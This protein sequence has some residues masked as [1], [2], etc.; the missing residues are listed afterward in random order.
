[1]SKKLVFLMLGYLGSLLLLAEISLASELSLFRGGYK[2]TKRD[3]GISSTQ[4]GLGTRYALTPVGDMAYFGQ[5]YV[6]QTS[7]G[8]SGTKPENGS[9]ME[10]GGG[11]LFYT[12]RLAP[13]LA[14]YFSFYG[15][16]K[17][18]KNTSDASPA[19]EKIT[20]L[21]YGASFGM[22]IRFE[23]FFIDLDANLFESALTETKEVTNAGAKD[24]TTRTE[25][26]VDSVGTF[27]STIVAFG[28]FL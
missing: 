11:V 22:Q 23:K 27:Q 21:Y 12:K 14:P 24:K 25:L 17:S 8:G 19:V 20:G 1:M 7:Y 3:G 28:I 6:N 13:F 10:L 4:I 15:K 26:Y 5:A 18:E 9:Q 2:S 16:I